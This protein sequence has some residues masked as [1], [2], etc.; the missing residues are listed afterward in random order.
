MG[1]TIL[2]LTTVCYSDL[3]LLGGLPLPTLQYHMIEK[4]AYLCMANVL[5]QKSQYPSNLLEAT[6]ENQATY[7]RSL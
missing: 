2:A 6:S 4:N 7:S 1:R 3:N 5:C